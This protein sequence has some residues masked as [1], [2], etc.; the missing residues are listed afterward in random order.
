MSA[1]AGPTVAG[2]G[3]TFTNH[4]VGDTIIVSNGSIIDAVKIASIVSANKHNS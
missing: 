4:N 2:S 3:T 1:T